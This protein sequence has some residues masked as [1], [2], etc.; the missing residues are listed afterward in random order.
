MFRKIQS[1]F[2]AVLVIAL[3]SSTVSAATYRTFTLQ[4]E[5]DNESARQLL[6][7]I[8]TWRTSGDAWYWNADNT[9]KTQ[10]GKLKAYTYDYNLEMIALQ[11]AYESCFR[12]AESH[13]RPDGG[14]F[15]S[16]SYNGTKSNGENVAGG[17]ASS[18]ANDTFI[19]L[20]ED[21]D[22]Y[23]G[24]GHRRSMASSKFTCMGAAHVSY[25]GVHV[26]VIEYGITNS[27]AAAT[28]PIKGTRTGTVK[29]DTSLTSFVLT[30]ETSYF[31]TKHYGDVVSLPAVHGALHF[32]DSLW[33]AD[34]PIPDSELTGLT[35][36]SSNTAVVTIQ[37]NSSFK[38]VGAGSATLT[39]TVTFGGQTYSKSLSV[40]TIAKPINDS[41][42]TV[43]VP[44]V[45]YNMAEQTPKP[46]IKDGS[47]TL[48]EGTDYKITKYTNNTNC[49]NTARVYYEGMGHYSGSTSAAFTINKRDISGCT[50]AAVPAQ[51]Y[52]STNVTP[53]VVLKL[54]GQQ[55]TKGT[56]YSLTY[57]DNIEPGTVTV[58]VTGTG[59]FTGT[60]TTTFELTARSINSV[61]IRDIADVQYTGGE[62]T[63]SLTITHTY[64]R[65][66]TTYTKTL[67]KG[68]DYDVT[69]SDNIEP[70]TASATITLK[71]Y[72]TG[73]KTVHFNVV[74]KQISSLS[75]NVYSRTY[76]GAPI[77][78]TITLKNGSNTLVEGTDYTVRY[79][80]NTNVGTATVTLTGLGHY[81]GTRDMTFEIIP[82]TASQVTMT[83]TGSTVYTGSAITPQITIKKGDLIFTENVDYTLSI[84]DNVEPGSAQV[85]IT[86]ISTILTGTATKTF[87]ISRVSLSSSN[88]EVQCGSSFVY[89]GSP[90]EPDITISYNGKTL[91]KDTDYTLTFYGN[92]DITSSARI[93]IS[94]TG[95][96]SGGFYRYFSIT[97]RPITDATISSV[98][99]VTYNGSAYTPAVTVKYGGTT[100]VKD[101]DYTLTYTNNT[102][103]GTA[104]IYVSGKGIYGGRATVQF[105]IN[106]ISMS[107]V[108]I[109]EISDCTFTGGQ[110]T[111]VPTVTYGSVT[112]TR[113]T[114]YTLTYSD[115]VNAGTATVTVT[116]KGNYNGTRT[117]SFTID[118]ASISSCTLN[119][120][121][122]HTYTGNAIE[123]EVRIRNSVRYLVSGQD[124]TVSYANNINV[125]TANVTVTG[126]GNY[127]GTL[128]TTFS[129]YKKSV[130]SLTVSEIPDQAYTG[131][132][133]EP[134]ITITDADNSRT[135][136][137]GTD[138]TVTY[139]GN[140]SIGRASAL[141]EGTG[142]YSG[143]KRVYFYI[144][145]QVLT[146]WQSAD[147]KWYYY[148]TN[149]TMLTGW[150]NISGKKYYFDASGVMQKG[151]VKVS[152]NWYYLDGSG[153][154]VTG[155]K[156][157][158][159]KWYFL[160][161]TSGV[162]W[163]G[164]WQRID[165]VWYY[166]TSTGAIATG[167]E[168]IG[169][170]W[171]YFN[172][173]GEMQTG[174]VKYN[175]KWYY[176]NP[177]GDMK[178]SSWLNDG[179][180]WYYFDATGAMVKGWLDYAGNRY[181]LD[182]SGA[183]VANRTITID[184]V[185]YSF[186]A[187]GHL[188]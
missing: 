9:T 59:N 77:T 111:P 99:P 161:R 187:S 186:D 67:V 21:N 46:V 60:R 18:T 49:G 80:N 54:N 135:L 183:M 112:L 126:T 102:N 113:N 51:E 165:D 155:W 142:N 168:K 78:Q 122:G 180:K 6:T 182:G 33:G 106:P 115:H 105:T 147:G 50:L 26:W 133:V 91:V 90:I 48:V 150:Q 24:Q 110:N 175:N 107:T 87:T 125:G 98:A 19:L 73:T 39:C 104:Y 119:S 153:A 92:T 74:P 134:S 114:D 40:T 65:Y 44:S 32:P 47:Y 127:T 2:A 103:A 86:G 100:L 120:V 118:P 76:T 20:R 178:A 166:F 117:I 79:A 52:T 31:G 12:F 145:Q 167:W 89:T 61:T 101:T 30:P 140:I 156:Y 64:P 70:G 11:R 137:P 10:C 184:G 181:Y 132:K 170:K 43:T 185:Q 28:T 41:S 93:Y 23:S 179:G 53:D 17:F 172:S 139:T 75:C 151:W 95:H 138:Y 123:P 85:T 176:L 160:D 69:Y 124:Y 58:T 25:N 84:T 36:K 141:I 177:Q 136:V 42:I 94:F 72:Y 163:T 66:S 130:A 37:N 149:G 1:F 3:F 68:T 55:L 162:M 83:V 15:N 56:H 81:A 108:T 129:I 143:A 152:S 8:N 174:W 45:T 171:Y 173:N 128:E 121:A 63:P 154:M 29:A 34:L 148:D 88:V 5:V 131:N 169:G 16:Y 157:I 4:Y 146:G 109:S 116:G 27:G 144:V 97:A 38:V 13:N 14:T 57:T 62:I 164:G 96:Y 71:G 7:E 22:D 159:N 82:V 188:K 158:G 35:W